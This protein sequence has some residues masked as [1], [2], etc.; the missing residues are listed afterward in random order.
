MVSTALMLA[1]R[2]CSQGRFHPTNAAPCE[3]CPPGPTQSKPGRA[4]A[5]RAALTGPIEKWPLFDHFGLTVYQIRSP[6]ALSSPHPP[7]LWACVGM[8]FDAIRPAPLNQETNRTARP[9][10][11]R[12]VRFRRASDRA[13]GDGIEAGCRTVRLGPASA[14]A[15]GLGCCWVWTQST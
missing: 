10:Y 4:A 11:T 9:T 13:S 2:F 7:T 6:I 8:G 15:P 3:A 1:C 12:S 14:S 5:G